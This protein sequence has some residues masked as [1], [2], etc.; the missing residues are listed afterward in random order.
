MA[1]VP[2]ARPPKQDLYCVLDNMVGLYYDTDMEK[3]KSTDDD[4]Q[5]NPERT[6]AIWNKLKAEGIL[7]RKSCVLIKGKQ[8]TDEHLSFVHTREHMSFI[9][10]PKKRSQ[11]YKNCIMEQVYFNAGSSLAARLAAGGAVEVARQ[12]VDKE[13]N[14]GFAIVRPPGHHAEPD[15]C[16]GFCLY[17]NIAVAASFLLEERAHC[18]QRILI[19]DW[20][21]HHGNG[22]QR[23]F[24]NDNRVLYFSI[25]RYGDFYP[26][27]EDGSLDKIGDG[28][29]TG[30][31][32]NV[33]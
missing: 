23:K 2:P 4:H 5:E 16:K 27:T 24:Y 10:N 9:D 3:H 20:D 15:G 28:N 22:T 13:I 17:N 25:H 26:Y 18:V 21:I 1:D 6:R 14:S 19:V 31:N 33:P 12:V 29:G 7:K 8:A 30:F 32:I 11:R